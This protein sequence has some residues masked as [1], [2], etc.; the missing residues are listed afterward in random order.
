MTD[1]VD[2]PAHLRAGAALYT[3][4]R[5]HAA[6]DPWEHAWLAVR[7]TAPDDAALLQGLIQ[8]TA[9]LHHARAGNREG[10]TGLAG[11]A[12]DYLAGVPDDHRD[13]DLD[14]IRAFLPGLAASLDAAGTPPPLHIDGREWTLAD[15]E[16]PAAGPAAVALAEDEGFDESP[17]ERAVTFAWADLADSPTSAFADAILAFVAGTGAPRTVAYDR[18][19]RR[20]EERQAKEDDV[21]GLFDTD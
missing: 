3:A 13:V 17:V 9:A 15:L 7:D 12:A 8:T 1:A 5:F 19:R 21:S 20:V 2:V 14:P 18:L 16:L 6:H 10:A 11:S 4:G